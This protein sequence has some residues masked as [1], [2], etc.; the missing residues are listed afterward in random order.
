MGEKNKKIVL[1]ALS[2]CGWCRKTKNLLNRLNIEYQC[3]EVDLLEGKEREKI[4]KEMKRY[5]PNLSF[6]TLVINDELVIIGYD[7]EKIKKEFKND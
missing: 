2:T 4:L 1:Y 5:N 3:F 6:P 7:E